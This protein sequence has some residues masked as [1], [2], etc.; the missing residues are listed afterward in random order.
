MW[1]N[2]SRIIIKT[3]RV[4]IAN[5]L[6]SLFLFSIAFD[7]NLSLIASVALGYTWIGLFPLFWPKDFVKG[8]FF[9]SKLRLYSRA[10]CM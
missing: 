2:T 4:I 3:T 6:V 7:L 9:L 5:L 8:V 1:F 10:F